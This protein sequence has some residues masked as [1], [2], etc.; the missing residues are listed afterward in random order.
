MVKIEEP[1]KEERRQSINN[2]IPT[3]CVSEQDNL[4]EPHLGFLKFHI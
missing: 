2:A 4:L 3:L 1:N